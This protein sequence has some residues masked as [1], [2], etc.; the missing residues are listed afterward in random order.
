MWSEDWHNDE[1]DALQAYPGAHA[2]RPLLARRTHPLVEVGALL[3]L[4]LL[5][6]IA[7]ALGVSLAADILPAFVGGV[8]GAS[9]AYL[10]TSS[11][12]PG[13]MQLPL[14]I[15]GA[16]ALVL[17]AVNW[18]PYVLGVEVPEV[19]NF[20]SEWS[21]AYAYFGVG[22]SVAL[23][24]EFVWPLLVPESFRE[25]EGDSIEIREQAKE[26]LRGLGILGVALLLV[27][28]GIGL[29]VGFLFLVGWLAVSF[30]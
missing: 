4:T 29:V 19:V 1:L 16:V 28:G 9:L 25:P 11:R 21:G 26:Y 22:F 6:G 5:V 12:I 17:V 23:F 13:W 15:L 24:S 27:V 2:L 14:A 3:I 8:L 18:A 7:A 10:A 30:S 20:A